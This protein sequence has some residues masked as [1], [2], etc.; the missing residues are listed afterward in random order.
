MRH[1]SPH[2]AALHRTFDRFRRLVVDRFR[3]LAFWVSVVLPFA[4]VPLVL[5]PA[6]DSVLI[7]PL[8]VSHVL[9][10]VAGHSYGHQHSEDRTTARSSGGST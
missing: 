10:L 7:A 3:A 2:S 1:R 5:T 8:A 9:T 6:I 4:Y